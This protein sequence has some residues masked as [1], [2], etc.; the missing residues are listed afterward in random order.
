MEPP[1]AKP[2]E[3]VLTV[4][5][6]GG[7]GRG[8]VGVGGLWLLVVG[9]GGVVIVMGVAWLAFVV[10]LWGV[11][12]S[13]GGGM[14]IPTDEAAK[15]ASTDQFFYF[16]LGRFAFFRSVTMVAMVPTILGHVGVRRCGCL[17]W[18]GEEVSL[19]GLI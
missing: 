9:L 15:V 5:R 3:M 13:G 11:A 16:I 2:P 12:G 14:V 8:N 19:E 10:M 1:L 17:S 4:P 6:K 18:W 7:V